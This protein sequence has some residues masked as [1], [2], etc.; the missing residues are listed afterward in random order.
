MT[1]KKKK[2]LEKKLDLD[3][4]NV[5]SDEEPDMEKNLDEE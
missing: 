3:K 2:D 4:L 1:H 5:E